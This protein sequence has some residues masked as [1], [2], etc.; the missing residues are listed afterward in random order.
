MLP[1]AVAVDAVPEV[2]ARPELRDAERARAGAAELERV[3]AH[4]LRQVEDRLHLRVEHVLEVARAPLRVARDV[5]GRAA[6]VEERQ[7]IDVPL[8]VAGLGGHRE[9]GERGQDARAA[10]FAPQPGLDLDDRRDEARRYAVRL[11]GGL[12][13]LAMRVETALGPCTPVRL[14]RSG[15]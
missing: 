11:L 13:R 1:V 9:A 8:E 12:E 4:L 3:D 14:V 10:V 5:G 6:G 7:P 15:R 2:A